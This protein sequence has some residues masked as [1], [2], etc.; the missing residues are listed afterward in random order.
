MSPLIYYGANLLIAEKP[1]LPASDIFKSSV[2]GSMM[3]G[4]SIGNARG[5]SAS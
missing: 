5:G 2:A 1:A 4:K 3:D